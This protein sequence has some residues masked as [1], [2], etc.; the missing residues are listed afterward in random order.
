MPTIPVLGALLIPASVA[1]MAAA[2]IY[3]VAIRTETPVTPPTSRSN[4]AS[5]ACAFLV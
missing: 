4:R 2:A 1:Y 5:A 3:R